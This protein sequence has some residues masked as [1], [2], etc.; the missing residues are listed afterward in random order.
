MTCPHRPACPDRCAKDASAAAAV[1][2]HPEQG[3]SLLCNGTLSFENTGAV[4]PDGRILEPAAPA[5]SERA[6]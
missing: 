6:A 4:L 1:A 3:W 5:G 2:S